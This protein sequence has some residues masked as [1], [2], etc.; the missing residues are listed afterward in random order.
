VAA[1]QRKR[2]FPYN[3]ILSTE[4][5]NDCFGS[6]GASLHERGFSFLPLNKARRDTEDTLT[7][8][9]RTPVYSGGISAGKPQD[10]RR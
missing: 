3:F 6:G 4:A 7:T 1:F 2:G 10:V 9:K 5:D 8:L